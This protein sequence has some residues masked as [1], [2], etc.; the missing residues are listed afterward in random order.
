[1][2]NLAETKKMKVTFIY[3]DYGSFNSNNINIGVAV[4][5]ACLKQSG[6]DTSLIHISSYITEDSFIS[7]IKKHKPDIIAVSFISN[8]FYQIRK[9]ASWLNKNFPDLPTIYGGLH[10]TVAPEECLRVVGINVICRGEGEEALID[11][12]EAIR[13]NKDIKNIPN[14][15]VKEKEYIYKNPCRGLIEKLDTLPFRDYELFEYEKLEDAM[16]YKVLITHASRGCHYNCTYCC[17]HV[18]RTLYPNPENYVRFYSVDRILDEIE[19]HLRKYPSLNSVRFNDDTLTCDK[20]WFKEFAQ[21][22]K[23]KINLPYSGND[24][25]E[26]ILPEIAELLKFSG[27]ISLDLGI[28]NG[29]ENIRKEFM[30]RYNSNDKIISSFRLLNSYGIKTNSFNIIGMVGETPQTILKT[31]KLNAVVNPDI[32]FN[33]Y[34]YPFKATEAYNMC[35]EKGFHIDE[36]IGSFFEKPSVILDTVKT[37]QL[38]FFYK[39]F[40]ILMKVYRLFFSVWDSPRSGTVPIVLDSILTSKYFPYKF[41]NSVYFSKEDIMAILRKNYLLY[42]FVRKIYGLIKKII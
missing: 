1:M 13:N 29:D 17:N 2:G 36:D 37:E 8:M 21:K 11:F 30:K 10:P 4:L 16:I 42:M 28:E 9:F 27:C 33:A 24:R 26:N 20:K 41:L 15:W 3:T 31:I 34:F 5:S 35:K 22:Y 25:V 19:Y 7:L 18:L 38:I 32:I 39:C 23:A 14:L 40:R 12:C 6:F